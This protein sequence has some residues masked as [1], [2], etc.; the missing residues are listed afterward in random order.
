MINIGFLGTGFICSKII[1]G[2]H[3]R[4]TYLDNH[5]QNIYIYHHVIKRKVYN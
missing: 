1:I 2:L 3:N 5:I 4:L